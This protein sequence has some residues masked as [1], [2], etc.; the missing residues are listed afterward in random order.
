MELL[1]SWRFFIGC[2]KENRSIKSGIIRSVS[3]PISFSDSAVFSF[4]IRTSA[5]DQL[6][7]VSVTFKIDPVPAFVQAQLRH[8]DYPLSI[9]THPT[10]IA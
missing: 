1:Q 9:S 4:L 8:T 3:E 5:L 7:S 10:Q 6:F 2:S